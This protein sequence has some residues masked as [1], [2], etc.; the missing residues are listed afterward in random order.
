M[1]VSSDETR[2]Y[3]KVYDEMLTVSHGAAVA[4]ALIGMMSEEDQVLLVVDLKQDIDRVRAL[5]SEEMTSVSSSRVRIE[6]LVV[7]ELSANR[8]PAVEEEDTTVIVLAPT[9]ASGR[10]VTAHVR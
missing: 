3:S 7:G 10:S 5:F 8:V 2:P 4:D 6:P 9:N 1:D